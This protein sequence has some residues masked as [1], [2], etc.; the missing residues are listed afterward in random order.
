[1]IEGDLEAVDDLLR[2]REPPGCPGF[3]RRNYARQRGEH[4]PM[5]EEARLH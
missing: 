1:M 3:A 4:V 5:P 2:K